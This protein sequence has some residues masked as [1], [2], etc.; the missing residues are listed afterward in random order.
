M[1]KADARPGA[2]GSAAGGRWR[3]VWAS[4]AQ[5]SNDHLGTWFPSR[6]GKVVG[7][8]AEW[9]LQWDVHIFSGTL[10]SLSPPCSRKAP[11][12]MGSGPSFG[13]PHPRCFPHLGI[14]HYGLPLSGDGFVSPLLD[15][16]PREGRPGA[17]LSHCGVP[18]T[19]I[20]MVQ[21]KHS[22]LVLEQS[23]VISMTA[24]SRSTTQYRSKRPTNISSFSL[25]HI[26][27]RSVCD[28]API[29]QT[30]KRRPREVQSFAQGHRAKARQ[31]E[32]LN[33]GGGPFSHL[34]CRCF[35]KSTHLIFLNLSKTISVKA[36][37]GR[38]T[39]S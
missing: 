13:L 36:G 24:G 37:N 31:R 12:T 9:G 25:H 11:S 16:E 5:V 19:A 38:G 4:R 7:G 6:D 32:G 33:P 10:H 22:D 26:P 8:R 14:D 3:C 30:R 20:G 28:L 39:L 21:E 34:P 29:L 17:V 35:F 15:F 1:H 23:P 27:R 2:R 18:S